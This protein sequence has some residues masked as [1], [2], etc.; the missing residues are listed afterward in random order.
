MHVSNVRGAHI[1]R[2]ARYIYGTLLAAAAGTVVGAMWLVAGLYPALWALLGTAPLLMLCNLRWPVYPALRRRQAYAW[3]AHIYPSAPVERRLKSR[4]LLIL[5]CIGALL[6][7]LGMATLLAGDTRL[8]S[9]FF[10]ILILL[11]A[12]AAYHIQNAAH[13]SERRE[14]SQ[15]ARQARTN[16]TDAIRGGNP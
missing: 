1:T 13:T 6:W 14:Q 2:N 15:L 16:W 8:G 4:W 9:I 5:C 10:I 12:I 7:L 11:L 3:F